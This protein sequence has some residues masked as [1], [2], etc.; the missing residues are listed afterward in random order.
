MRRARLPATILRVEAT[1][2]DE[3]ARLAF[4]HPALIKLAAA[5]VAEHGWASARRRLE[6][7]QGQ[8]IE[9]ALDE[10]IGQM[11]EDLLKRA[12]SALDLL[13][14]ALPFVGGATE[15]RLRM[16][17]LGRDV[18]DEDDQ[19]IDFADRLLAPA[20]RANLL[21]RMAE[22]RYDLDAPVRAYLERRRPPQ[23]DAAHE[24]ELRHAEAHVAVVADYE[25]AITER[26]MTYSAPLEWDNVSAAF[27]RLVRRIDDGRAARVLLNFARSW[28]NV[29]YNNYDPRRLRW[30][31]VARAAAEWIGGHRDR[32]NTHFALGD[33]QRFQA[34]YHAA[35]VNYEAALTLYRALGNRLDEANTLRA[36]GDV[37]QFRKEMEAALTSYQQALTLFRAVSNRQ[38]EA[39]TLWAIG[40]VQRFRNEYEVALSNYEAALTLYRA[41]GDRV[42][43]A[44]VLKAIGDVQQFRKEIEAALSNYE[45]ALTL[46]RAVGSPLGEARTLRALGDVWQFRKEMEAALAS[47]QQALTLYRV[48]GSRL[49]EANTIKVIGDVQQF[50]KEME[51]ALA[52]YQQA[53]TL[54]QAIGSRLGEANVLKAIGDVQQFRKEMEAALTS[55]QQALTLF[56][57]IGSRL[58]E[59]NTIKAIG[60]VQQFRVEHETALA[61]YQQALTLFRAVG[62]RVGEASTI[63]AIGDVQRFQNEYEAALASYDAALALYRA[64]GDRIGEANVL[65]A[66]GDV[67]QFRK[68]MEAALASYQQALTL[69]QA[70]GS[71][72]GEANTLAAQSRLL[73][74]SHPAKS[75]ALLEQAAALRQAIDDVYGQAAD[76]YNY[77]LAL[78]NRRRNDESLPYFV[79]ARDLFAS[80]GI[81][82]WVREADKQIAKAHS[83][84]AGDPGDEDDT[85]GK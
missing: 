41:V 8:E 53:L 4:G 77:G 27:D 23:P 34:E 29:L 36:L 19:A 12:P 26:R 59:A 66:L 11:L 13:H 43:E 85:G 79:R 32:A 1:A 69:F 63:K 25:T 58:G 6:R 45:A 39:N 17:A 78:L 64:V 57:A 42:G 80:R 38:G 30:L 67:Q 46:Y 24:Y 40:E 76:Q 54:F 82:V 55:Y 48:V 47:Y 51:A 68:E 3:L 44:N 5:L 84:M 33:V 52:S 10:L 9:A 56:Q 15:R 65:K 73:I 60:D 28:H 18:P 50:R 21:T 81:E 61:S 74:D 83:M 20:V 7:L 2:L 70:V 72:L 75:Q 16:V 62:D 49:G 71:R 14:A 31:E 22:G 35:Q 37:Q